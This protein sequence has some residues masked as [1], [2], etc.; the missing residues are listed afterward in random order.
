MLLLDC[1]WVKGE[2]EDSKAG[3]GIS[4]GVEVPESSEGKAMASFS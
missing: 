1:G 2:G 4:W 3:L